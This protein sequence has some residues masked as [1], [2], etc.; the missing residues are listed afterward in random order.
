M[1]LYKFRSL[2]NIEFVLDLI[3]NERLHCAPY[4]ELN[5][6]FE[7]LFNS[8]MLGGIS[9]PLKLPIQWEQ[10]AKRLMG[11]RDLRYE[12]EH[13][14]V[15]SLS[16]SMDD[17]RL[18]SHYADGHKGIAI[19][20]DFPDGEQNLYKVTYSPSLPEFG[21]T[22]MTMPTAT[23]VLSVKTE[24]WEYEGEYRIIQD[25]QY[26]PIQGRIKAIY[27]GHRI[28]PIHDE[29][30]EKVVPEHIPIIPTELNVEKAI[31]QAKP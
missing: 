3:L 20:I 28:S 2:Q 27:T 26:Y 9:L 10:G 22:V 21:S 31:V 14:R 7:G 29:L 11:V 30:L 15:C 23:D 24:H 6:P 8:I 18:W 17:V 4:A 19:E 5:D 16:K 12:A 13:S 25:D 1:L